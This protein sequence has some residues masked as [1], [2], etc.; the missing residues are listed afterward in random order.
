VLSILAEAGVASTPIDFA[1]LRAS[2]TLNSDPPALVDEV[3][4]LLTPFAIRWVSR[5]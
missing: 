4:D 3:L 1:V 5:R 2:D